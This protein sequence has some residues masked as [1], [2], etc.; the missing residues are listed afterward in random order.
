M[1]RADEIFISEA[2]PLF[3]YLFPLSLF[4]P[5][6]SKNVLQVQGQNAN[7]KRRQGFTRMT[8]LLQQKESEWQLQKSKPI[9][10][11]C[12]SC[13][14]IAAHPSS[15]L[16]WYFWFVLRNREW[17]SSSKTIG[18]CVLYL[19]DT[20]LCTGGSWQQNCQVMHKVLFRK[21]RD[22]SWRLLPSRHSCSYSTNGSSRAT[23]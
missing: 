4:S 18:C 8:G 11:F 21:R 16:V 23:R 13:L 3:F 12:C 10:D 5:R 19:L 15:P 2:L 22:D 9:T 6:V 7:A 14:K 17:W 1:E 20:L